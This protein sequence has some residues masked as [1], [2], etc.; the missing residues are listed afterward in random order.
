MFD[1]N[2]HKTLE[3]GPMLVDTHDQELSVI[4]EEV[5]LT[6]QFYAT[7]NHSH[8]YYLLKDRSI[9]SCK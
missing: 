6:L 8:R 1:G 5:L 7:R 2:Q 9:E 4:I 3:F